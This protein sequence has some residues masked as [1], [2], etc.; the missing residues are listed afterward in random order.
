MA[1]LQKQFVK[2][3]DTIAVDYEKKVLADKRD[4]ILKRLSDGI[5]K[6]RKDGAEIPSY[7]HR[8]QGSYAM[9]TG[10]KPLDDDYDLDV[11]LIFEAEKDDH[12]DPVKVKRW[13]YDALEGHTK[14]VRVREPCVTV[15]YQSGGE[16]VFHVDF[17]VYARA[18]DSSPTYLARGKIGSSDD[19]KSWEESDPKGLIKAL[20]E[21]FDEP[22]D[23]AQFRR[24]IRYLK[25]WKDLKFSGEGNEA[26]CGIALT[27][28][29]YQWFSPARHIDRL[30][31][32][33]TD[34]DRHALEQLVGQIIDMF[35]DG[36]MIARL[37]VVPHNDL[38]SKMNERQMANFKN[39]LAALRS[40]LSDAHKEADTHE[41]ANGLA[42]VFG[43]DFPVPPKAD[44]AKKKIRPAIVPSGHSG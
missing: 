34:D 29:A 6:Q 20:E 7:R 40:A 10:I 37:P 8:N 17:A 25:R 11:A 4:K 43:G 24:V 1:D 36:R 30:A 18:S 35:V 31:N 21:R 44:T 9:G 39:Q 32:S 42:K 38:F 23:R 13:V 22:D 5:K 27:A 16:P 15:F 26:P 41:A 28:C 2:F 19:H 12:P 14:E 3:H 33:R